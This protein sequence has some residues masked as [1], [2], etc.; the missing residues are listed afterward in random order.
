MYTENLEIQR[1]Q[2][3][4][5]NLLT[6]SMTQIKHSRPKDI[7][8]F[9]TLLKN[10]D[11]ETFNHSVRV[12]SYGIKTARYLNED[13]EQMFSAFVLH[14]IGKAN[15]GQCI[16]TNR[17]L[18][19]DPRCVELMK[20]HP[21]FSYQMLKDFDRFYAEVA[22]R[23]HRYQNGNS[24]PKYLPELPSDFTEK[25]LAK[26][27][28]YAILLSIIDSND[29]MITRRFNSEL[30]DSEMPKSELQKRGSVTDHYPYTPEI[31]RQ[32]LIDKF[33][34]YESYFKKFFNKDTK[35]LIDSFYEK[36]I[37][38]DKTNIIH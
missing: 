6:S 17:S 12:G 23:H 33:R 38:S 15:L 31:V 32:K 24:Y 5:E 4:L 22:L 27:E 36:K 28:T 20:Q 13:V 35:E 10:V 3:D 29:A 2:E 30:Q 14:D 34:P 8:H 26:V 7:I 19:K 11:K 37:I 21:Y 16:L 18:N 25:D 1:Y 9:L